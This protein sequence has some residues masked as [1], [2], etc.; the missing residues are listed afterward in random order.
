MRIVVA[1]CMLFATTAISKAAVIIE[2]QDQVF[3]GPGVYTFD[4]TVTAVGQTETI[5]GFTMP[6]NTA[7]GASF[8]PEV[9]D[10][11]LSDIE[12]TPNPLIETKGGSSDFGAVGFSI[13]AV[14][15]NGSPLVL[16]DGQTAVLFS[17][18]MNVIAVGDVLVENPLL[19]SL[20]DL[21]GASDVQFAPSFSAS[22]QP[23]PE[24]ASMAALA[25]LCLIGGGVAVRRRKRS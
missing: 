4:F 23:V 7:N 18:P 22:V 20:F 8:L 1:L 19:A 16:N 21:T 17:I 9:P 13:T 12:F 2:G 3:T 6:L 10:T 5:A 14:D 15:G 25:S 11:S 24:P